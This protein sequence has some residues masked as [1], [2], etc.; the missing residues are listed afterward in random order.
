MGRNKNS[1]LLGKKRLL[2]HDEKE[3]EEEEEEEEQEKSNKNLFPSDYEEENESEEDESSESEDSKP[4]KRL[5]SDKETGFTKGLFDNI[6]I[7]K[8]EKESQKGTKPKPLFDLSLNKNNSS[9]LFEIKEDKN[10]SNS[11]SMFESQ[12]LFSGSSFNKENEKKEKKS[13][14]E[15]ENNLFVSNSPKYEYKPEEVNIDGDDSDK[16]IKRYMKKIEKIFLLDKIEKKY[17]CK[18]EGFISLETKTTKK[19]EEEKKDAVFVFRNNIGGLIF[20]GFLNDKINS[21]DTYEKKGKFFV[22]LV[23]LMN[24]KDNKLNLAQC[25]IPFN[26]EEDS[27]YF[28]VIYNE[29]IKYIKN[30]I[31]HFS[32]K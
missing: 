17:I 7:S 11:F 31:K 30:E 2:K 24:D 27:K 9:S 22:N 32:K 14:D 29:A 26:N 10:K 15:N 4:Q 20:E 28:V 19:N 1:V 16:Y 25:K 8:E 21:I 13:E 5:F 12:S 23:F 18:G 6:P 3:K